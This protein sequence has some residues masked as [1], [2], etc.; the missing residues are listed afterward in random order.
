MFRYY[1]REDLE[2]LRYYQVPKVLVERKQYL[3]LGLAEKL[4]YGILLDRTM[5]SI[6]NDWF[7][8]DG[9]AYILFSGETLGEVL[10]VHEKTARKYI[11]NLQKFNLLK[12]KRMG[13]G[14]SNRIYLAQPDYLQEDTYVPKEE[15]NQKNTPQ[16]I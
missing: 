3:E 10:G 13:R 9:H 2:K 14:M 11:R 15:N 6:K 1:G 16:T 4:V 5:L 12:E 7:D 8:E